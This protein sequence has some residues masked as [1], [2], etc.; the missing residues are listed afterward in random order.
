MS[1]LEIAAIFFM[2]W[3]ITIPIV[4]TPLMV[5]FWQDIKTAWKEYRKTRKIRS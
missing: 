4:V 3:L 5:L 1:G 2:A